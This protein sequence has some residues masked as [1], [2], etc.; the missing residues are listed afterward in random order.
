MQVAGSMYSISAAANPGVPG[1]GW[2]QSTGHT[3]VH[4]AS[5]QQ[6]CV[7]T[8]VTATIYATQMAE[9]YTSVQR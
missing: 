3:A 8:W 7:I 5:L 2:M 6:D 1:A 9:R 4:A